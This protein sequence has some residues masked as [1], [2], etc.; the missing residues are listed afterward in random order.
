MLAFLKRG[1]A[2]WRCK[3]DSSP[4]PFEAEE[5]N[6]RQAPACG[7]LEE[8]LAFRRKRTLVDTHRVGEGTEKEVIITLGHTAES[9]CEARLL[10][11]GKL[12]QRRY[13]PLVR[14]DYSR[15]S[16]WEYIGNICTY[17]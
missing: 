15:V 10:F 7:Y 12:L 11:R 6:L 3:W 16:V 4:E 9:V 1:G 5:T 2:K 13:M 17:A 8:K 14:E